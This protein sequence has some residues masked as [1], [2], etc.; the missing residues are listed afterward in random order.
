MRV[1]RSTPV[2]E[3]GRPICNWF[4]LSRVDISRSSSK[5]G[6]R[7]PEARRPFYSTTARRGKVGAGT[8]ASILSERLLAARA[9]E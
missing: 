4:I 5:G 7:C 8:P 3:I 9:G 1:G 6:G 2:G